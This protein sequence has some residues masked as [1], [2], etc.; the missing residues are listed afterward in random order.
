MKVGDI[1]REIDEELRQERFEKLWQNYGKYIIAA[2]VAVVVGVGG[3]KAFQHYQYQGRITDSSK[4]SAAMKLFDSGKKIEAK[5][6]FS[7]LKEDGSNGYA[8]LSRFKVAA[9]KSDTGDKSGA[10][11]IYDNISVDTSVDK[12]LR[13]AAVIFSTS[14]LLDSENVERAKIEA[15]LEPIAKGSGAWRHSANE[16]IGLLA[17]QYGDLAIAREYFRKLSDNSEVPNNMRSRATQIL[18]V[19]G[20]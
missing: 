11:K 1:F 4:F 3:F 13:E 9:I 12:S 2:I 10:I 15:K 19:V 18:G 17:L 8:V 6:L 14:R 20:K 16:L 5:A 7:S